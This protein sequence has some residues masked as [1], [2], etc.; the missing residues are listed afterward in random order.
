LPSTDFHDIT[1][2]KAGGTNGNSATV[3]YDLATGRGTPLAQLVIRDLIAY[4]TTAPSVATQ[5]I[6]ES[7][8]VGQSVTFSAAATG[9][10]APTIQW[11]ISTDG[12]A[13][14]INIS[15]ATGATYTFTP[16]LGDNGELFRA[17][18]TNANSSVSTNAA[19]LNVAAPATISAIQV[20]GGSAQR[21]EVWSITVTFSGPVT[22]S[23]GVSNAAAAFQ[24]LHLNTGTNVVL[25]SA[26]S[27]DNTVVTLYFSGSD[28][29][30]LS[31]SNG[32]QPSLVDGL[33]SLSITAA[34][35]VDT[36]GAAIDADGDGVS[37]GNYLSKPDTNSKGADQLGLY[38]LYGDIN[39]DGA[40]DAL[41]LITLRSTINLT[42]ASPDYIAAFDADNNGSVDALDLIQLRSRINT[43]VFGM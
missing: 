15:G 41:D 26:V 32:G 14:F 39:G 35:I 28:T 16:T 23:G 20:N 8:T 31:A 6:S 2:G 4:G 10:P 5:P 13:T 43:N 22:F 9:T 27:A 34:A 33:Y 38:R 24:L 7:V 25:G 42:S 1:T 36:H 12:G 29:D 21:S 19:S 17:V 11:Q 3:G 30:A 18:F 37:G 40:V